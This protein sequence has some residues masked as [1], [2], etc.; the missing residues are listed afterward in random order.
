VRDLYK[1]AI[2]LS[3][4]GIQHLSSYSPKLTKDPEAEGRFIHEAIAAS[5]FEHANIRMIHKIGKTNDGRLFMVIA[6]SEGKSL[7]KK[8]EHGPLKIDNMRKY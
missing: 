8:I 5:G 3:L 1:N 7:K 2:I 6:S 4:T